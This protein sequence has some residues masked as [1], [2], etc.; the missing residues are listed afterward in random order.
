MIKKIGRYEI[1]EEIGKGAMG[2]VYRG[3]DTII[4]RVVAIKAVNLKILKGDSS[5]ADSVK[6]FYHEARVAGRLSHPNIA[7]IYDAG[8]DNKTHY[9]IFEYVRG[10]TL[11]TIND[12]RRKLSNSE[13]L[14]II[15]LIGRALH[16]AHQ[17]GVIHR[18]IKPAN[19]M[20][21]RDLRIK[22]LD[23]GIAY[24]DLHA[25]NL[26]TATGQLAGTPYY[27]SPEQIQGFETDRLTDIFSLGT[28]AYE[29]LTGVRPFLGN[30]LNKLKR[31]ILKQKPIP[32]HKKLAGVDLR[33]NSII[34][35]ALEKNKAMRYQSAN[36]FADAIE[37]YLAESDMLKTCVNHSYNKSSLIESLKERYVFFADFTYSELEKIFKISSKKI[38]K[39]DDI[40]YKEGSISD[41]LY[42]IITGK[43]QITKIFETDDKETVLGLL[44]EG[45]CFGEISILKNAPRYETAK[46]EQDCVLIAINEAVLRVFEPV[47]CFKLYKNISSTLIDKLRK[48]YDKIN[49]YEKTIMSL[50]KQSKV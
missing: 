42:I 16:Y 5:I 17:K 10:I 49:E 34:Q 29:L 28:L 12:L 11:K 4:D 7:T 14:K 15:L 33:L 40:I 47:L 38:Y 23:F 44:C 22:I 19:I 48:S 20:L 43:V 2:V 18:D 8:E 6:R 13:K 36:E 27:M 32:I 41:K 24:L 3:R 9:L 26:T 35:K 45:D 25:D 46:V 21:L 31:Q 1:L 30:D 39:K 50:S 37:L